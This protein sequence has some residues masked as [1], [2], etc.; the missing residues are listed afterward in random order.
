MKCMRQLENLDAKNTNYT[1]YELRSFCCKI[2][3]LTQAFSKICDIIKFD[4][5]VLKYIVKK[6]STCL[7]R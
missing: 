7:K 1:P 3:I 2:N 4:E 5:K 6:I